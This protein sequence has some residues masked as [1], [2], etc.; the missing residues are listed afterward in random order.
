MNLTRIQE[1]TGLIPGP[2][3]WVKDLALLC[4]QLAVA[5]IRPPAWELPYAVGV[6][7][8]RQKTKDKKKKKKKTLAERTKNPQ[9]RMPPQNSLYPVSQ[10][11]YQEDSLP[12]FPRI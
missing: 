3:Q 1:D 10:N 6:A 4:Q 5:P 7:L 11:F 8:K 12:S 2:S 9:T